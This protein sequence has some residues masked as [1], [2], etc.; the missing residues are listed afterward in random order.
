MI[1][2]HPLTPPVAQGRTAEI[3]DWGTDHILKLYRDWCP[4][5]WVENE[6]RVVHTIAA[7]G[8]PTPAAGEILEV[9]GRRGLVYERV[10]GPS[11]LH[12]L[13][14]R[15]WTLLRHAR[16]LAELQAQFHQIN[17]PGLRSTRSDLENSIRHAPHLPQALREKTLALVASLPEGDNLCH[18]DFHPDNIL[19]ARGG[20]VI[21]DWMTATH[22]SPWADVARTSML[23]Q[24]GARAAGSQV[25]PL[26]L[27]F[28][29]LFHHA[30]LS[31]YRSLRPDPQGEY[32]RWMPVIC[33]ARLNEE[34]VKEREGL[35]QMVKSYFHA[36]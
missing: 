36:T 16:H 14:A 19:L 29:N 31:R 4:A 6:A 27:Q 17:V 12:E 8:I 32:A 20:P 3:F 21:I 28:I 22:G 9:N 26:V 2:T 10:Q 5:H 1:A 15:P 30:Y 11:M 7:A 25:N 24:V 23:L 13:N 18:G 35:V 33:A 34:I